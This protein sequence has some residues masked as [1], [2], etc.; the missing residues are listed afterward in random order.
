[1]KSAG[2][3]EIK[4]EL[5]RL[6]VIELK[7]LITRL[8]RFRKE[9]KELLHYLLFEAQD[10][11]EYVSRLKDEIDLR[12]A[13]VNVHSPYYI[14]KSLRK[15][16]RFITLQSRYSGKA[17][18]EVQLLLYFLQ[19]WQS[20]GGTFFRSTA[21]KGIYDRQ[22]IKI[23]KKIGALHADLQFDYSCELENLIIN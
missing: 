16:L 5:D 15:I 12:L 11:E 13:E 23:Q 20:R 1:M 9:N 14:A 17:E 22:I 8:A 2:A 21:L 3:S 18:T 10:E 7:A 4:K 6:S 19:A